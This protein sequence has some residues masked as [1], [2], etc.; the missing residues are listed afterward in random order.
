[1]RHLLLIALLL[2]AIAPLGGCAGKTVVALVPDQ[3]GHTGV[4]FVECQAG[5]TTLS[6][7]YQS[8]T[9]ADIKKAPAA[10]EEVGK[11]SLEK[12]FAQALS[13]QPPPPLHF[14]LFY[15]SETGLRPESL[16]LLPRIVAAIKERNSS[17]ISVIGHADTLGTKDY[18]I[19]VSS[20]RAKDVK[21]ML[22]NNGVAPHT[23][24]TIWYGEQYLLVPTPDN[25][26][27]PKNRRVEIVVR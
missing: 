8:T 7:P 23:I 10:P 3:Q 19:T 2:F 20:W 13:Y 12:M 18:N 15:R 27:N 11:N 25:M 6:V 21:E 17:F 16:K 1:M 5:S 26:W 4:V 24:M 14:L 22:I 9:I